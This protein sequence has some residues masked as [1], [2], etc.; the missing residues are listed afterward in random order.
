ME[1]TLVEPSPFVLPDSPPVFNRRQR[2]IAAR[3]GRTRR[4]R[5]PRWVSVIRSQH[6]RQSALRVD[7]RQRTERRV[8][9]AWYSW[10]RGATVYV[11]LL[12][13]KT[14]LLAH[15]PDPFV[16]IPG[17]SNHQRVLWQGYL[18]DGVAT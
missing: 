2:R 15:R 12:G 13:N 14:L 7:A 11:E 8:A 4:A 3:L 16:L 5:G 18:R 10:L 9:F 1:Q 17:P 6:T